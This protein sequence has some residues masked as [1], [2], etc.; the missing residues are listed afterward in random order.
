MKHFDRR[1][2]FRAMAGGALVMPAIIQSAK[3]Q[4]PTSRVMLTGSETLYYAKG[5]SPNG[6]GTQANP[7]PS[8]T[9]I[10]NFLRDQCDLSGNNVLIQALP[11][12]IQNPAYTD[13]EN[14]TGKL[15]GSN[16]AIQVK[17][18]GNTANPYLYDTRLANPIF[19]AFAVNE[20]AQLSIEGFHM[21]SSQANVAVDQPGSHLVQTGYMVCDTP[22]DHHWSATNGGCVDL[23]ADY[24]I[25]SST[26]GNHLNIFGAGATMRCMSRLNVKLLGNSL[27][28]AQGFAN[29]SGPC[30]LQTSNT[31]WFAGYG[32]YGPKLIISG[33]G[34][35]HTGSDD[36]KN[37]FP[38]STPVQNPIGTGG[39]LAGTNGLIPPG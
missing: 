24:D 22:Q 11:P 9:A 37:H 21:F 25:Q 29:L 17:V 30:S 31:N 18:A 36:P 4:T 1:H 34:Y 8:A 15:I 19:V 33:G 20:G 13:G 12:S 3:A 35:C 5:G 6:N 39:Y 7:Y 27:S 32:G 23:T 2:F 38:G 26:P 28:F 14:F 10:W 16:S